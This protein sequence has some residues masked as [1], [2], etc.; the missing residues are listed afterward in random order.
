VTVQSDTIDV[1][2]DGY[3]VVV[4]SWRWTLGNSEGSDCTITLDST[5]YD[6]TF[7]NRGYNANAALLYPPGS[8]TAMFADVPAGEHV[9]RLFCK[10]DA[11]YTVGVQFRNLTTMYFPAMM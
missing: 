11:A 9:V 10:T 7:R 3:L 8:T 6:N 1:P 4:A 5:T 2:Y